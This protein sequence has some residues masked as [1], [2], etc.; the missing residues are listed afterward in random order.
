MQEGK[1]IIYRWDAPVK[2]IFL[3]DFNFGV[4]VM[5]FPCYFQVGIWEWSIH[6]S[7]FLGG[8]RGQYELLANTELL[9]VVLEAFC[10]NYELSAI[11]KQWI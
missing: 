1:P 9:K 4:H 7:G 2:K 5:G 10:G 11:W 8:F 6:E 3:K